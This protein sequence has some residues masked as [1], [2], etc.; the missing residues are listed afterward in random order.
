[1]AAG[2]KSFSFN[3]GAV[4][5]LNENGNFLFSFFLRNQLRIANLALDHKGHSLQG[6][7]ETDRAFGTKG[8]SRCSEEHFFVPAMSDADSSHALNRRHRLR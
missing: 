3:F 2:I 1:M 8:P 4:D 5:S 7:M 6:R